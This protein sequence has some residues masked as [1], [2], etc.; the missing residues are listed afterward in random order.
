MGANPEGMTLRRYD[1]AS[2][3]E[4]FDRLLDVYTEVYAEQLDDPFFTVDRFAERVRAH[5]RGPEFELVLAEASGQPAGYI[6]GYR[7]PPGA[8]WWQGITTPVDPDLITERKGR[9]FA[10]CEIM[11]RP[12]W[13]GEGVAHLLHETLAGDRQ[14]ARLTLLV[15]Q[16]NARA[17]Q[18]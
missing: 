4:V 3:D 10:V 13:Q 2:L 5:S 15:E 9:T 12:K 7:L 14:E 1:T 8:R 16:D 17:R 6:Y 18:I 11:V